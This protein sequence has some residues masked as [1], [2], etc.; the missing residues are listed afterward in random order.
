MADVKS[1]HPDYYEGILQL[2]NPDDEIFN[3]IK[4]KLDENPRVKI[5]KEKKLKNGVDLYFDD[6]KFLKSLGKKLQYKFGAQM[7]TSAKLHT[8]SRK[9]GKRLY[10]LT[11]LIRVPHFRV[12]QVIKL[13]GKLMRVLKIGNKVRVKEEKTGKKRILDFDYIDERIH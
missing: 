13:Q 3:Y 1:R 10:R 7:K 4:K 11:V 6:Q 8:V 9:T 12:G 2:R 5:V